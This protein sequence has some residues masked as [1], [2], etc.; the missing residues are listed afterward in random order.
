MILQHF[1]K[2]YE[3]SSLQPVLIQIVR[4]SIAGRNHYHAIVEQLREQS[5]QYHRV[6]NVRHLQCICF[7]L[8]FYL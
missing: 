8:I 5:L 3:V 2:R 7:S 4:R 6:C 1:Y